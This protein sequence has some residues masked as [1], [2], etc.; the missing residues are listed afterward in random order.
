MVGNSGNSSSPASNYLRISAPR[1]IRAWWPK[2]GMQY[3]YADY[4]GARNRPVLGL[5]CRRHNP[6]DVDRAGA[7]ERL[8]AAPVGHRRLSGPVV[9]RLSGPQ[10]VHR[11]RSLP[12]FRRGFELL[13]QSRD[14][15]AGD[16]V[17]PAT[18]AA[19]VRHGPAIAAAGDE[20]RLD[21]DHGAAVARLY[22]ADRHLCRPVGAVALYPGAARGEDFRNR[23]M[24]AVRVY[25]LRRGDP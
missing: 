10:P 9:R 20:H 6:P 8:S 11:V 17:D 21:P 18:D 3:H 7:L 1:A 4:T 25:G 22:A 19:R 12:A 5:D 16:A 13:D 14:S 2:W 15:G 24:F 23:K